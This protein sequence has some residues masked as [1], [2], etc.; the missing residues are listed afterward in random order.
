MAVGV[1]IMLEADV[2]VGFP[3]GSVPAA[4]TSYVVPGARPDRVQS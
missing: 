3:E 4:V 2:G 1:V